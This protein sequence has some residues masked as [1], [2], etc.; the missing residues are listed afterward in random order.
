MEEEFLPGIRLKLPKIEKQNHKKTERH[1]HTYT[2]FL[3]KG[4]LFK[5]KMGV[6][7]NKRLLLNFFLNKTAAL[8]IKSLEFKYNINI[9]TVVLKFLCKIFSR[10][11]SN[12]YELSLS[13]N[14][15]LNSCLG[16]R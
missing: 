11:P 2:L 5:K 12:Y 1:I 9:F 16:L 4:L 6:I 3:K 7:F 15:E 13:L 8:I 14:F 10:V